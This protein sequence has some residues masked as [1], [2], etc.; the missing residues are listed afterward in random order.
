MQ[1]PEAVLGVRI[2]RRKTPKCKRLRTFLIIPDGPRPGIFCASLD[3]TK[4]MYRP[5]MT[6]EQRRIA[7]KRPV[8]KGCDG[9]GPPAALRHLSV[10]Y[11]DVLGRAKQEPEPD[12]RYCP[13]RRALQAGPFHRNAA[14]QG[15]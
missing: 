8:P 1:E 15:L 7:Q 10:E 11:M 12:G 6:E 3:A 5:Y 9:K 2:V 13:T 14:H 4:E